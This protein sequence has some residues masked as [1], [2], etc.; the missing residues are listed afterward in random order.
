MF[1][2][3][4]MCLLDCVSNMTLRYIGVLNVTFQKQPRRK[5]TI[6]KDDSAVERTRTESNGF[7]SRESSNGT[8]A[9][10]STTSERRIVS[11]SM[12]SSAVPIPTVTFLDNRHILPRHLL[13][14]TESAAGL[15]GGSASVSAGTTNG[16]GNGVPRSESVATTRTSLDERHANSWGATTVNKRLRNEVFNDAFLK[17]PV[18]VQRHRR[19]HQRSIRRKSMGRLI[20]SPNSDT[21]SEADKESPRPH[22]VHGTGELARDANLETDLTQ[23]VKDI[24][25]TSAP[26]PD[27]LTDAHAPQRKRQRRYSGSGLRRKPDD[28]TDSR[29]NLKYFEEAD[30]AGYKG[31]RDEFP[32]PPAKTL[33]VSAAKSATAPNGQPANQDGTLPAPAAAAPAVVNPTPTPSQRLIPRP[34]NPKEAQTQGDRRVEYFLLLEDLTAGMKRPCI[35]DLKMGTRQYG[36]DATPKKQESQQGKCAKTTSRELGV[37]VCGLQVWDVRKQAY[38]FKDKYFGRNL[39]AGREFQDALFRFLYDGE[40]LSSVLRHIPT[41]LQRLSEL[42]VIIRSLNGYRFY[43]ASLLMFYDGDQSDDSAGVVDDGGSTT[44]FQTDNEEG[45]V[46]RGRTRRSKREIDFKIADFANSVTR[47]D[48]A[49]GKPCPPLHPSEP[50]RGFLRGLATLRKYFLAIQREVR[51]QMGLP[52]LPRGRDGN[53]AA[54]PGGYPEDDL[55]GGFDDEGEVSE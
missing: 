44:D 22:T 5:S 36:V 12:Q 4:Y 35:M 8:S 30:D 26:E 1:M 15:T 14:P 40:N 53:G 29:G 51:A 23:D 13:Q 19:A 21:R 3:L 38:V 31:E 54:G 41:I 7:G 2:C 16:N 10:T 37:R 48:L 17:Q 45:A 47:G 52:E 18:S 43:A 46:S 32:S 20:R 27:M 42:E 11:Q 55:N 6:R 39:K 50:D 28:V 9:A 49:K 25:G 24:T 33:P 34:V